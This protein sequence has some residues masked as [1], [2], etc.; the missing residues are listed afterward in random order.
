MINKLFGLILMMIVI[1][2]QGC[3]QPEMPNIGGIV[4]PDTE[5]Y[6]CEGAAM[7]QWDEF[8]FATSL[9]QNETVWVGF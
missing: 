6:G 2:F 8:E 4:G 7:Y 5:L 1:A 9:D 3:D